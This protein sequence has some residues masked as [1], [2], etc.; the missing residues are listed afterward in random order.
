MNPVTVATFN[1]QPAAEKVRD[2][3]QSHGIPA[4]VSDQRAFQRIWFLAKPY[5]SVHLNVPK[6]NLQQTTELLAD[7]QEHEEALSEA[8]R[9]PQ[10]GSL[11]VE[12]PQMTRKF[13][14]PTLIAHSLV[15]FGVMQHDFYCTEC[16]HVWHWPTKA[17]NKPIKAPAH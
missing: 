16:Q 4:K 12:Y 17:G 3:L 7:W 11:R 6:D 13:A 8:L 10:C 1:T 15:L 14:L 9:C 2:R 5:G